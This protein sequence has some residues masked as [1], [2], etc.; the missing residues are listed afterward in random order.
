[1]ESHYKKRVRFDRQYQREQ[2][3]FGIFAILIF[4]YCLYHSIVS[5]MYGGKL[6]F[7]AILEMLL[8]AM[9]IY[10]ALKFFRNAGMMDV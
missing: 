6:L 8:A 2:F 1:M 5:F 7:S 4:I 3:I 10:I 9:S